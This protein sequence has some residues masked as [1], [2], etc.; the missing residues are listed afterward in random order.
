M[1][2]FKLI[3]CGNKSIYFSSNTNSLNAFNI[4]KEPIFVH[5]YV[6]EGNYLNLKYLGY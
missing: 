6:S 4:C 2:N 1:L 5:V 3:G